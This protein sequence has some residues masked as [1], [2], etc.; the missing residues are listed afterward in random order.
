MKASGSENEKTVFLPKN[1]S[2]CKGDEVFK[3]AK[4]AHYF[5]S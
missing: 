2:C 1:I 5:D 4:V 3:L